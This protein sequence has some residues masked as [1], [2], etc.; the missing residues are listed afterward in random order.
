[1]CDPQRA[2]ETFARVVS[3]YGAAPQARRSELYL[4]HILQRYGTRTALQDA[5]APPPRRR[6]PRRA[7]GRNRP[8][9]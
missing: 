5:A 2:K 8:N 6:R 7:P 4:Q 3:E 9:G 1:M